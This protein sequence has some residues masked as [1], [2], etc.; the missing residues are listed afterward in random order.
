MDGVSACP[1]KHLRETPYG[2]CV[3]VSHHIRVIQ[4]TRR[5]IDQIRSQ[6]LRTRLGHGQDVIKTRLDIFHGF[7]SLLFFYKIM[8]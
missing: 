7:F 1:V 6:R 2:W 5:V 8:G 3:R 4:A